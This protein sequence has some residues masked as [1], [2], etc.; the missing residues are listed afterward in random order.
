MDLQ[1][2]KHLYG[3]NLIHAGVIAFAR[4]EQQGMRVDVPYCEEVSKRLGKK[5]QN[6]TKKLL[7]SKLGRVWAKEYNYSVRNFTSNDQLKHVL[8]KKLGFIPVTK[9]NKGNDSVDEESLH[10]YS[11]EGIDNLINIRK[12]SK[13]KDTYIANFLKEQ[14][15]GVLRPFFNL[16]TV[17]TL[18]SSSSNPNFQN[19]PNRIKEIR[20]L[21]RKAIKPRKG[22]KIAAVD[23][24]GIEVKIGCPYH[25]D[26]NMIKY[27]LDD[28]TDMHQ[29]TASEIFCID[30]D[31]WNILAEQGIKKPI[32]QEGKGFVFAQFYGDWYKALAPKLWNNAD[33]I[34]FLNNITLKQH[35]IN[36]NLSNYNKFE[37]HIQDVENKM[38]QKRFKKYNDWR[39][40]FW[41]DYCKKGYFKT[42]TGFICRG[43]MTRN[44]VTN[45]PIQGTAFHCLL[46]AFIILDDISIKENWDS[47]LIGQIHDEVLLD[48]HPAEE[49]H[50][51]DTVKW[52]MTVAVPEIY[53]FINVPLE[54]EGDITPVD[55]SWFDIEPYDFT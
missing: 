13:V 42:L 48:I 51:M 35:L 4:A 32:R 7:E 5:V 28:S 14:V 2:Y 45:S 26:P 54:V 20:K 52:V 9:T 30:K 15:D 16:H 10:A 53:S 39:T 23:F 1:R 38:W 27:I 17:K 12:Y 31:E 37:S 11:I 34:E 47:K 55:G 24:G 3:Y 46:L 44:E 29:D 49:K 41:N 18:R 25:K 50:V 22:H 33:D 8:Y 36:N 6:E 43:E 21:T 40:K 19:I